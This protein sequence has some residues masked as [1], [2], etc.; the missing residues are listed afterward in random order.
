MNPVN[1][2]TNLPKKSAITPEA[3]EPTMPKKTKR[4]TV[5]DHMSSM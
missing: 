1:H 3:K 2:D 4:A 5:I